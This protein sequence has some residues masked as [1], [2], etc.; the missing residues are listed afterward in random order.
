MNRREEYDRKTASLVGLRV[1]TV[2]Y[3]DIHHCGDEPRVWDHGT[4]HHAV[5]GVELRTDRGPF[6]VLWSNT[7]YPYGV[8]VFPDPMTSFLLP[9][10]HQPESWSATDNVQ[11]Q[12]RAGQ[13]VT[14]VQTRWERLELGPSVYP[15]GTIAGPPGAVDLPV[16]LRLDFAAGPVWFI[17]GIPDGDGSVVIP[18]DEIIVAFTTES[19][20]RLGFP[21]GPF[22]AT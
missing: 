1:D 12:A 21:H 7:F 22:T 9:G 6:S 10:E 4:W 11:W 5:M 19:M 14:D 20:H 15:D 17:A 16:A 18:G 8:E 2:G 13:P 3:W